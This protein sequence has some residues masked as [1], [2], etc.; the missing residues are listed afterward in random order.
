MWFCISSYY[1]TAGKNQNISW[2]QDK[3]GR[4]LHKLNKQMR[5][6]HTPPPYALGLFLP[7]SLFTF[8]VCTGMCSRF[9][10]ARSW[11]HQASRLVKPHLQPKYPSSSQWTWRPLPRM[12]SDPA[13]RLLYIRWRKK[14]NPLYCCKASVNPE[15]FLFLLTGTKQDPAILNV[16]FFQR[17]DTEAAFKGSHPSCVALTTF[18]QHCWEAPKP[19]LKGYSTLYASH[20]FWT[21][22]H[23]SR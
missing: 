19:V 2:P 7:C 22:V 16:A 5:H 1:N 21:A 10:R 6:S 15:S 20:E 12:S 18:C 17:G 13:N 9:C 3:G 4:G 8:G 23:D 14:S 11:Q